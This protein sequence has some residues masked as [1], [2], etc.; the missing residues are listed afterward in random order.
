MFGST[1]IGSIP[2]N[3]AQLQKPAE[4]NTLGRSAGPP[5][6]PASDIDGPHKR[7]PVS[8]GHR[9]RTGRFGVY[10]CGRNDAFASLV[11]PVRPDRYTIDDTGGA[12]HVR[13]LAPAL[14]TAGPVDTDE[15]V[16]FGVCGGLN[17]LVRHDPGERVQAPGVR[18][19]RVVDRLAVTAE[20]IVLALGMVRLDT[21]RHHHAVHRLVVGVRT[22]D[23]AGRELVTPESADVVV[24][25]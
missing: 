4:P 14:L 25:K 21:R 20:R 6:P 9:E 16:S 12:A 2:T 11:G 15:S 3:H 1:V 22:G 7:P 8:P 17:D 19:P 23:R 10:R 13:D 5:L 18:E 24:G